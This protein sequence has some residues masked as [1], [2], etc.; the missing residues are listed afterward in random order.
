MAQEEFGE[1]DNVRFTFGGMVDSSW[2]AI[3]G[4]QTGRLDLHSSR[5]SKVTSAHGFVPSLYWYT[6]NSTS[7]TDANGAPLS[8]TKRRCMPD[9]A[10]ISF[11][12]RV[13]STLGVSTTLR[14]YST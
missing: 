6:V 7:L 2:I 3:S 5:L 13:R 9:A 10:S 4:R 8:L 12:V 1:A 14:S 11:V